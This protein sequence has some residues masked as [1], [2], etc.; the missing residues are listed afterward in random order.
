MSGHA[1]FVINPN[2]SENVTAAIH[3]S[4][5]P[6]GR[7]GPELRCETLDEGPP[8]IES[9][10]QADAVIPALLARAQSHAEGAAAIVIACFG[11]PGLHAL[12]DVMRCPVVGIQEAAVGMA[13]TLGHRFGILAI[14]G[15]SVPRHH[16]ALGA[17]GVLSRFAASRPLELS[18]AELA[19]V[20][21]T[22]S[23]LREVGTRLR[24]EDGADVL[25]LGCAG[26][27]DQRRALEDA[28]GLPVVEPCQAGV[29][30]AIALATLGLVS[31]RD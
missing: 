18:V 31:R 10:A 2:S 16:R 19:D 13:M 20:A 15:R 4:V 24:D 1:I 26:M 28:L 30:Q 8:G 21:T 23:R 6:L 11:D 27:A 17:M 25:I 14:L 9:Q 3:R 29:A 5:Q 22:R 7:W 12:R